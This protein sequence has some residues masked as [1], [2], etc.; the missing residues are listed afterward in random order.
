MQTEREC[1]ECKQTMSVDDFYRYADTRLYSKCKKCHNRTRSKYERKRY[2]PKDTP[3]NL[4]SSLGG[5]TIMM[6]EEPNG[7]KKFFVFDFI[8]MAC[9]AL[10]TE[11]LP[12]GPV[13]AEG[14]GVQAD[15]SSS[16]A[17]EVKI[18]S[19]GSTPSS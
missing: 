7:E 9:R 11:E 4:P 8:N 6:T 14:L 1:K 2:K 12:E 19:T 15:V 13:N 16:D 5:S 3:S 10:N 17:K 18:S